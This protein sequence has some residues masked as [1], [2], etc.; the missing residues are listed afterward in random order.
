[1]RK[2]FWIY[3]ITNSI[4][5]KFYI[6]QTCDLSKRKSA[7]R[8]VK[9]EGTFISNSIVKY[10]WDNHKFEILFYDVNVPFETANQIEIYYIGFYGGC[11]PFNKLS[12]NLNNG[13]MQGIQTK[14]Q[15]RKMVET[16]F[17]SYKEKIGKTGIAVEV[18][19]RKSGEL[20]IKHYGI[21]RD[22]LIKLNIEPNKVNIFGLNRTLIT[23]GSVFRKK[24]IVQW[25]GEGRVEKYRKY[26]VYRLDILRKA[27][28]TEKRLRALKGEDKVKFQIPILDLRTGVYYDSLTEFAFFNKTTKQVVSKGFKKGKY[29]G[30]YL[31]S[32][33]A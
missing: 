32:K 18:Y 26:M 14:N 28:M 33:T 15:I 13:G 20:L 16:K 17:A 5:D 24:Y 3:K 21:P 7:H 12:M 25:E 23:N 29:E 30:K 27:P 11:F 8:L 19:D 10:G 2:K 6:G 31:L 22:L 1:M 9:S 4:T